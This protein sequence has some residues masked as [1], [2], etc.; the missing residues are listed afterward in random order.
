MGAPEYGRYTEV[1]MF[2]FGASCP[3]LIENAARSYHKVP[4]IAEYRR[5]RVGALGLVSSSI[6]SIKMEKVD[7]NS[8]E[9]GETVSFWLFSSAFGLVESRVVVLV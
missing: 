9:G 2:G 3:P 5:S 7:R 4:A 8:V 1:Q 6:E